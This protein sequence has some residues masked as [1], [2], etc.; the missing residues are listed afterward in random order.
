MTSALSFLGKYGLSLATVLTGVTALGLEALGLLPAD[1]MPKVLL[2]VLCLLATTEIVEKSRRLD[3]IQESVDDGMAELRQK[4]GA[5]DVTRLPTSEDAHAAMTSA[6]ARAQRSIHHAAVGPGYA[7]M[8]P[9]H[10][11]AYYA[12]AKKVLRDSH[13]TYKYV[14]AFHDD[15]RKIRVREWLRDPVIRKYFVA[16]FPTPQSVPSP[17]FLI[18]DEE[19]AFIRFPKPADEPD[20]Y[21]HIRE[22]QVVELLVSYHRLLWSSAEPVGADSSAIE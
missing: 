10:K 20:E 1:A 11:R 21:L 9:Q 13:V 2:V 22:P 4:V 3:A 19:E 6:I 14:T 8:L 5:A 18:I 16:H 15:Q 17:Y 12:A 7:R